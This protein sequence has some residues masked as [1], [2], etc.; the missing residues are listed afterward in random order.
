MEPRGSD[1][2]KV[3]IDSLRGSFSPRLNGE[4]KSHIALL[5]ES[6]TPMPPILVDRRTMR[7]IDG[8]H[9]LI[10]ASRKGRTTIDVVF[11]DGSE[12]DLFLRAVQENVEHGLPLTQAERRVAA[13]RIVSSHAHLSDRAIGKL[14]GLAARTIATIRKQSSEQAE[15][16]ARVGRDGKL[17]PLDSSEARIQAAELLS[18]DRGH[19]LR[20]IA[21]ATGISPATVAD[22]RKRLERGD[23][24]VPGKRG[25]TKNDTVTVTERQAP[26]EL[27]VAAPRVQPRATVDP[28]DM[29]VKLQR[30]PSMRHNERGRT[31]LRLLLS[32]SVLETQGSDMIEAIPPHWIGTVTEFARRYSSMWEKLEGELEYRARI[33]NP[34]E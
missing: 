22:V 10:A 15:P 20:Y 18:S 27:C 9:R 11:F 19:S 26:V 33:V 14:T 8:M 4:N 16:S 34:W 6:E 17:R 29:L 21:R 25:N 28:A 31:F 1:I 13:E 3:S 12:A 23:S 30:D 7:V 32:T 2:H 5:V 24:P